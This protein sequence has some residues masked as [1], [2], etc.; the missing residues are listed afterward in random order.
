[1]ILFG[2]VKINSRTNVLLFAVRVGGVISQLFNVVPG[3]LH[4]FAEFLMFGP[5]LLL[6]LL[7]DVAD[8]FAPGAELHV[9]DL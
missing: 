2:S 8:N 1:M 9:A 7:A 4:D 5:V 3:F 6:L